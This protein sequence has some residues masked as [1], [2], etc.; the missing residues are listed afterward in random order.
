V[1]RVLVCEE[2][3]LKMIHEINSI[4]RMSLSQQTRQKA[5][6]VVQRRRMVYGTKYSDVNFPFFIVSK[7]IKPLLVRW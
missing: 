6:I 2:L 4:E 3:L 5:L 1:T 7:V